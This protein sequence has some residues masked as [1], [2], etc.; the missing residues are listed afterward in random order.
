MFKRFSIALVF[1]ACALGIAHAQTA[2]PAQNTQP[3]FDLAEYGV[4][5]EPDQR[6]IVVMAALD[7]AG[8]DPTGAG[9]ERSAFRSLVRKDNAS[10]DPR[11]RERLKTF[12]E[13]NKLPATATAAQQAA[14]YVSLAYALGPVPS[15]DPPGRSDDLPGGVLEVLDFAPL[16]REYYQKSGI[17]ERLVSYLRAYQAEGDRIRKPAGEMVRAVLSYLHTRPITTTL[18]RVRVQ[19][20]LDGSHAILFAR[21]KDQ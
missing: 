4:R 1:T 6:L 21:P 12:F 11:L 9:K 2:A 7:A 17:D 13:L 15:L 5:L 20:G 16:V 14:R 18:E 8:F 19:S 10:L 3:P